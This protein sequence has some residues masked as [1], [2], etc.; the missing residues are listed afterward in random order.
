M[1]VTL[2]NDPKA[3]DQSWQAPFK[4]KTKCCKCGSTARLAFVCK[5][6][7]ENEYIADMYKN[8]KA[9]GGKAWPHDA[10]AVAVYFCEK[11]LETTSEFNQA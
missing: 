6:D 7:E 4:D 10:V 5:E 3:V 1:N 8:K 2:A 9:T 11:C